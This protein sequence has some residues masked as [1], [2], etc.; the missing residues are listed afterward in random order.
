MELSNWGKVVKR[1]REERGLTQ[2]QLAERSGITRGYLSRIEI[3]QIKTS[4]QD[5]FKQIAKGLGMTLDG[6]SEAISGEKLI[7]QPRTIQS[8]L[9]EA[10]DRYDA[11]EL[12]ELP[13]RGT[14]PAGIPFPALPFTP[15]ITYSNL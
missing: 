2:E 10:K 7:P 5:T 3:G 14:V 8:I 4:N 6:L 9:K 12:V 11:L 13:L 1:L 15:V